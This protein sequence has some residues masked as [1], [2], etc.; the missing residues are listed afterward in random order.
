[1]GI[2]CY[3][4]DEE[5][6]RSVDGDTMQE[7]AENVVKYEDMEEGDNFWIGEQREIPFFSLLPDLDYV[8][9][10]VNER[11][12]DEVGECA[13]ASGF[14]GL[15]KEARED[16]TSVIKSWITRN[17]ISCNFWGVDNETEF[18]VTEGLKI[19]QVSRLASARTDV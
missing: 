17:G 19:K 2:Y 11:A 18:H 5:I 6:Y 16:F 8:M 14:K 10:Y 3:S 9:D 15:T 7:A 4:M 13:E 1:M 12:Y